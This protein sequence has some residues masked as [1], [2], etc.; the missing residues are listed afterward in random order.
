M[1]NSIYVSDYEARAADSE[2]PKT[3]VVK[4]YD[5]PLK[6]NP[7]ASYWGYEKL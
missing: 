5:L 3:L 6:I 2:H 7:K 1:E 4:M